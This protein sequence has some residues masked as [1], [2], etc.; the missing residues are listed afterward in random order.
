[1]ASRVRHPAEGFLRRQF[2]DDRNCL[3]DAG[4]IW[5]HLRLLGAAAVGAQEL[6]N[7]AAVVGRR[8][9]PRLFR[10]DSG[11]AAEYRVSDATAIS[12]SATAKPERA[13]GKRQS[14]LSIDYESRL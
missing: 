10:P 8:A 14:Q 13:A 11:A 9:R 3:R 12:E 2:H 6:R 7:A 5:F 1:M 4:G